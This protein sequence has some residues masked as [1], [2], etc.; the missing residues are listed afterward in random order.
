MSIPLFSILFAVRSTCIQAAPRPSQKRTLKFSDCIQIVLL[1]LVLIA[2]VYVIIFLH[3]M[4]QEEERIMPKTISHTESQNNT[5]VHSDDPYQAAFTAWQQEPNNGFSFY[6]PDSKPQTVFLEGVGLQEEEPAVLERRALQQISNRFGILFLHQLLIPHFIMTICIL[7]LSLIDSI[8]LSYSLHD[9]VLYGTD[10]AVLFTIILRKLFRFGTPLCIASLWIKMPRQVTACH[11]K[12]PSFARL[13]T[14]AGTLCIFSLSGL[15]LMCFP[16]STAHYLALGTLA[17]SI[18]CMEPPYQGFY[19]L[20]ALLFCPIF[21]TLLYHGSM[22]H[23]LRQFGDRTA[24]LLTA[25][26]SA[27]MS[28]NLITAAFTFALSLL[29]GRE[30][31]RYQNILL[32]LFVRF[33]YHI[34]MFLAFHTSIFRDDIPFPGRNVSIILI[35]IIGILLYIISIRKAPFQK[36]QQFQSI[37]S[38]GKC[39]MTFLVQANAMTFC[40]F[41]ALASLIITLII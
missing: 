31:L 2:F 7:F 34:L 28:E 6:A 3:I 33:V 9:N 14:F 27:L 10:G 26:F 39:C 11:Q 32:G 23:V 20:F 5:A 15:I 1:F 8:S 19:F 13:R 36:K 16:E 25:I 18:L 22:L 21:E 35:G 29:A 38:T 41:L 37:S 12:A 30:I 4:Q 17:H 40:M 24:I